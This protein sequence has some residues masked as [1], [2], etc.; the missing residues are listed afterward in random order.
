MNETD[1]YEIGY[2]IAYDAMVFMPAQCTQ[3]K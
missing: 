1:G 2:K 3:E